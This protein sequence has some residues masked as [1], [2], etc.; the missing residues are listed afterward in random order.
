MGSC[1]TS[2]EVAQKVARR[3]SLD[4]SAPAPVVPRCSRGI[5]SFSERSNCMRCCRCCPACG[6]RSCCWPASRCPS[7]GAWGSKGGRPA[8]WCGACAD[9][10]AKG[11]DGLG[12]RSGIWSRSYLGRHA[13]LLACRLGRH[14]CAALRIHLRGGLVD[15]RQSTRKAR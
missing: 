7:C 9:C 13:L 12:A 4:P 5:R 6:Y 11:R 1:S 3:L 10:T 8:S 2:A 15:E 14:C